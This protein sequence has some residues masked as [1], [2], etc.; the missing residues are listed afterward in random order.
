M[1]LFFAKRRNKLTRLATSRKQLACL[2]ID[3]EERNSEQALAEHQKEIAAEIHLRRQSRIATKEAQISIALASL[4]HADAAQLIAE[5]IDLSEED[6]EKR[7][8]LIRS[9]HSEFYVEVVT[10]GLNADLIVSIEIAR[11]TVDR[12]RNSDERGDTL[13]S[14]ATRSLGWVSG[15]AGRRGWRG[16]WRRFARR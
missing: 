2:E 16:P 4:S 7:F 5:R 12:A 10:K 13:A 9:Q 3:K 15:R 11:L 8:E 14:S 1:S 6:L